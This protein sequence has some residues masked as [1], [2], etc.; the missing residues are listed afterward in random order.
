[1]REVTA[2]EKNHFER[3]R[4]CD[5]QKEITNLGNEYFDRHE[6]NPYIFFKI[7]LLTHQF[8]ESIDHLHKQRRLRLE[9]VHFAIPLFYCGLLKV[10][11]MDKTQTNQMCK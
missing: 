11:P 1:M 7:L 3:Y 10:P 9:A 8:E 2:T 5:L 4:L 6:P